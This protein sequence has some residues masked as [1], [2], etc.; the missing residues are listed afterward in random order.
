MARQA[1]LDGVEVLLTCGAAIKGEDNYGFAPL[2]QGVVVR[3]NRV[4]PVVLDAGTKVIVG[5]SLANG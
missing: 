3:S 5:G 1:H 2:H 4:C